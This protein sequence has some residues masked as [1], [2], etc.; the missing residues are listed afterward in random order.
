[1]PISTEAAS[2]LRR[3]AG[4]KT[5]TPRLAELP[6]RLGSDPAVIAGPLAELQD[7]D[8]VVIWAAAPQGPSLVLT[9]LGA[10]LADVT[11]DGDRWRP[12]ADLP[13]GPADRQ[14]RMRETL[15][16]DIVRD[17]PSGSPGQGLARIAEPRPSEEAT[18]K[19]SRREDG[20]D[21]L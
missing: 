20:V 12:R 1:M 19:S 16:T 14:P 3:L 8:L 10:E 4:L 15:E 11:M 5:A 6:D 2:L 21:A 7:A 18:W 9:P 17:T 13:L